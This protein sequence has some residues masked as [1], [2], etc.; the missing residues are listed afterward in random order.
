VSAAEPFRDQ[1]S[2][3][4]GMRAE[5]EKYLEIDTERVFVFAHWSG[6][7]KRSGLDLGRLRL[8][9]AALFQVRDGKV[10]RHVIYL[11]R[12]RALAD[13]GLKG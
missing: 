13:L 1:L 5:A 2:A 10:A 6:H 11:D 8:E 4:E 12:A 9:G 3:W 7:G